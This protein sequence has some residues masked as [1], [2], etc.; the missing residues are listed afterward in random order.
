MIPTH[1][2][3]ETIV[4]CFLQDRTTK[5]TMGELVE[6]APGYYRVVADGRHFIVKRTANGWRVN[7]GG[8]VEIDKDLLTAARLVM[9]HPYVSVSK[10]TDLE[11]DLLQ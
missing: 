2:K 11:K 5:G 7:F 10:H 1:E 8:V 4:L 3:I 6:L 9:Q